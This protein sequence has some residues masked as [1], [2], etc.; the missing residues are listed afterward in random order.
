MTQLTEIVNYLRTRYWRE[1][2][3]GGGAGI[4]GDLLTLLTFPSIYNQILQFVNGKITDEE[5]VEA[6]I[7]IAE[8]KNFKPT[9]NRRRVQSICRMLV[10]SVAD[11]CDVRDVEAKSNGQ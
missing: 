8:S 3:F 7:D 4:P 1:C 11:F 10:E 2:A 9:A 6:I 5:T